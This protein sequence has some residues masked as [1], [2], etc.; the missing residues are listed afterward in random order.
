MGIPEFWITAAVIYTFIRERHEN[1]TA[2]DGG[3]LL[4]IPT[5]LSKQLFR[6]IFFWWLFF[7][8]WGFF[9]CTALWG[10]INFKNI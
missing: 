8:C 1:D 3:F 4:V 2:E 10:F 6:N 5:L 9:E 7:G